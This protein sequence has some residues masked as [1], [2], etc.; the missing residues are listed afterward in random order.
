MALLLSACNAISS[1][2]GVP[3]DTKETWEKVQGII[4]E[5]VDASKFKL[6]SLDL[7]RD[8]RP[9]KELDNDLYSCSVVMV[10]KDG[11]AWHQVFFVDGS[12]SNLSAYT[13]YT[14]EPNFSEIPAVDVKGNLSGNLCKADRG[15]QK[16][17]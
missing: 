17:N 15:C 10:D 1:I 7:G 11:A 14:E 5:K 2:V 9:G 13:T 6:V 3:T 16:N 4:E 8:S 12:A